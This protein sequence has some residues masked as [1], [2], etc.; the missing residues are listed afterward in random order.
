MEEVSTQMNVGRCPNCKEFLIAEELANH[1]CIQKPK[2]L[3]GIETVMIHN[4]F[5]THADKEGHK[6][7]FAKGLDGWLYRMIICEHHTAPTET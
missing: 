1:K 6:I 3:Q 7:L 2:R 4:Y 5:E